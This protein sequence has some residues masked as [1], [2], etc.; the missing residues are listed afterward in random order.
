MKKCTIVILMILCAIKGISQGNVVIHADPRIDTL[1][2]RSL[3]LAEQESIV[4]GFRI[5]LYSGSNRQMANQ[6]KSQFMQS[7]SQYRAYMTYSQPYFRIRVGDFRNR[8]EALYLLSLLKQDTRFKAIML[9][10]DKIEFP[11][12]Y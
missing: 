9:V 11:P 6:I 12:L 3:A 8:A 2:Q 4:Q 5:Q 7:Y 10:S 1:I